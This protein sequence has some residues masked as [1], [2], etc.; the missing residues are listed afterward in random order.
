[1]SQKLEERDFAGTPYVPVYVM[2]PVSF[3]IQFMYLH[4]IL[5]AV[6]VLMF[7]Y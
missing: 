5:T 7:A 6:A 3:L 1:M 2:L 4:L